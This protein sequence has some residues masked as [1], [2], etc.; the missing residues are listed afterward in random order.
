MLITRF[1]LES[2]PH[3]PP[4]SPAYAELV[5]DLIW[6]HAL[7][8]TGLEHVTAIAVARG[9]HVALFQRQGVRDPAA[10]VRDLI[11]SVAWPAELVERA[12]LETG[13]GPHR[14]EPQFQDRCW[15]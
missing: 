6:A 14:A 3:G 8:E 5:R 9:I 10:R 7:P 15:L 1:T 13:A 4:P 11:E 2:T 12:A